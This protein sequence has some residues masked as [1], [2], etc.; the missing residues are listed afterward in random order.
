[1]ARLPF[2]EVTLSTG[3]GP[4]L[5]LPA[6]FFT[7]PDGDDGDLVF[8]VEVGDDAIA[9]ADVQIDAEGHSSVVM[10]SVASGAT[11][12]TVT[13]ADPRGLSASQSTMLTVEESGLTPLQGLSVASNRLD[14]SGRAVIGRC[15]I[16]IVDLTTRVGFLMTV[17]ASKWQ[18]RSDESGEWVDVEGNRTDDWS[19]VLL[20]N[21]HARRVSA[22]PQHGS[23]ERLQPGHGGGR[24]GQRGTHDHDHHGDGHRQRDAYAHRHGPAG[25]EPNTES[26]SPLTT[27]DTRGWPSSPSPTG[28]SPCADETSRSVCRRS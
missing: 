18:R 26:L 1:M 21:D 24:G 25:S 10:R 4:W 2:P 6:T 20:R 12:L 5:L 27:R 14:F 3:G 16:P 9:A 8:T 11:E 13:A 28:S 15:T 7:D 17:V 22:R 23:A 19:P